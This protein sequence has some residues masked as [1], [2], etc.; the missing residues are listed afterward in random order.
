MEERKALVLQA[1]VENF[2]D[3]AQPIGSKAI[4]DLAGIDASAATIRSEMAALETEGFLEQ[5]HTSAGR[6]PTEKGYRYFVDNLGPGRLGHA[7]MRR[8]GRFFER[9]QGEIEQ[10][11]QDTSLLLS[12]LTDYA[13]V[14]VGPAHDP[15]TVRSAQLVDLDELRLL[16]VIVLSSGTVERHVV[17]LAVPVV[18]DDVARASSVLADALVGTSVGSTVSLARTGV[19]GVDDLVGAALVSM[20]DEP[21]DGALY[22]GGAANMANQFDAIVTVRQVLEVLEEQL[23][24]VSLLRSLVDRG[25]S[26]AIGSETGVEPL[27]ECAVVVAPYHVDGEPAG[28]IGLLGPTRMDY[29]K[30]LAAVHL[31]SNRLGDSLGEPHED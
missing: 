23:M 7:E 5:P 1:V 6:V 2:I 11:L 31:V 14:V 16:L 24:V 19:P 12:T 25:L 22:V 4:V 9:A 3:T 20:A 27:A 13:A 15:A 30:A 21:G 18:A 10:R 8:V 29:P 26:V 28:S 17:E